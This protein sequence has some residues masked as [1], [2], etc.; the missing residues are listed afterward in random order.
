[1]VTVA[2][3][4]WIVAALRVPISPLE[5]GLAIVVAG[6]FGYL[7]WFVGA[8]TITGMLSGV[9]ISL[10]T[11]VL[12]GYGWFAVLISFFGVGGLATRFRYDEKRSSGVAEANLG[13]RGSRNVLGNSAVA[14]IA[15]VGYAAGNQLGIEPSIFLFA[16]AGSIDH[17]DFPVPDQ[18]DAGPRDRRRGQRGQLDVPASGH[19]GRRLAGT[20][21][22]GEDMA[23]RKASR[24]A[25][26]GFAESLPELIGGSADLTGSN[27]TR[28]EGAR[29]ISAR[30]ADGVLDYERSNQLEN[31]FTLCQ[32]HHTTWEEFAP[33]QPDIR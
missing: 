27:L 26:T 25:L 12:G 22:R 20:H 23:T 32:R 33:L 9:L 11:I 8:A 15:V 5:L 18:L 16:F 2:L 21:K 14:V 17:R 28:W 29:D 7:S 6:I 24:A 31:L 10:L 1:M 13:A 4:L 19:R 3:L 30:D